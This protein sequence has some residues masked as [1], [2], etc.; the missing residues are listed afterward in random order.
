MRRV[1]CIFLIS[2]AHLYASANIRDSLQTFR[3]GI[4]LR[5]FVGFYWVNGV[6]AEWSPSI[7]QKR[8]LSAGVTLIHSALGSAAG[9]RAIP[10]F[11]G[12]ICLYWDPFRKAMF[13]PRAG[14]NVGYAKAWYGQE[15]EALAS[16]ALLFSI[17]LG[18][19]ATVKKKFSG[20]LTL[21]YN[22]ITGDGLSGGGFIFPVFFQG[23]FLYRLF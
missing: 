2:I 21:G 13:H 9:T 19:S 20:A 14:M 22:A 23:K 12:E 17:E 8:R 3:A 15:F 18:V 7:L 1:Y 10:L 16:H 6:T 5:K 11:N 4:A